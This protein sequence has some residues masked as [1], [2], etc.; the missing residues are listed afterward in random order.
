MQ[1]LKKILVTGSTGQLG[2]ELKDL[3]TSHPD[4]DFY[5]LTKT[6][7]P[8]NDNEIIKKTI[9][10]IQP[11]YLINCAAYTAVDKAETE[12]AEALQIN[13]SAVG[14]IA[15]V[16]AQKGI[17]FIHISTDYV[18]DG[19]SKTSLKED[20]AVA[21]INYYGASKLAGEQLAIQNNPDTIIIRTSWVYSF[22]GKNFVKTMIRLMGEKE[23]INVVS[24]QIG[25]P[26]YAADLAEV[27]MQIITA[28][29]WHPGIYHFSNE[30]VIS[31]AEFAQEIKTLIHSPCKVNSITTEQFPTAAKRPAY[32]VMDRSKITGV[33]GVQLKSWKL[34]LK[35]CIEKLLPHNR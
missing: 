7:L 15:G 8:L 30:G 16:C 31:W 27:I 35:A 22:Y 5:F 2:S 6:E 32:S 3:A 33:Y 19:T 13:G 24:D 34:S 26:T 18:F 9:T 17:K 12:K 11:H 23:A 1:P 28:P 20:D 10:Q 4:F 25:S 29:A 21:P 14:L